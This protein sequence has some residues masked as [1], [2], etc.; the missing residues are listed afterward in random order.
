MNQ[1]LFLVGG[2]MNNKPYQSITNTKIEPTVVSYTHPVKEL[3]ENFDAIC[4]ENKRLQAEIEVL[5]ELNTMLKD[6]IEKRIK[7]D[8]EK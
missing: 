3:D 6:A 7:M 1:S 2:K 8:Q 4:L 5:K